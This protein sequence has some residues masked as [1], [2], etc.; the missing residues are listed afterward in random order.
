M[1]DPRVYNLD[2][3]TVGQHSK[4]GPALS[5]STNRLPK[6]YHVCVIGAS[7]G[8]GAGAAIS[9]V[10]AGCTAL[11]LASRDAVAMASVEETIRSISPSTAVYVQVCDL[12]SATSVRDLASFVTEKLEKRLDVL[13]VGSG[14][15][16]T[17]ELKITDGSPED[18][19]WAEAFSV[20][21]LGT[22]HA[23]HY[24]VPLLL[25]SP[26]GS[27]KSFI[28][29]GSIAGSITKG[30]IANSKYCISKMA[31]TR[32][33]EHLS[34]QFG[35]EG[36]LAVTVHPGSVSTRM[37]LT[38]APEEFLKCKRSLSASCATSD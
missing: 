31:Q 27:A 3:F 12:A 33:M 6:P 10:R 37:A 16:G 25:G 1:S 15:S 13:V 26:P 7:G 5:P 35:D 11:V 19:Q 8:I 24:F 32:I 29:V 14:Y 22:Y 4:P 23:A 17:V 9:Y 18:G 20:N 36:L 2:H 34:N 30:I 21:A 28:V 38:T